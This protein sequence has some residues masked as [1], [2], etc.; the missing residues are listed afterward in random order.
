MRLQVLLLATGLLIL[1]DHFT[2][3]TAQAPSAPEN[4]QLFP[5]SSTS[6]MGNWTASPSATNYAVYCK[7]TS[8]STNN[9]TSVTNQTSVYITNLKPFTSY[10]CYVKA[11]SNNEEGDASNNS[12]STTNEAG[13]CKS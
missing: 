4:F 5:V 8:G 3:V 10:T 11:T 1:Y 13:T 2:Q 6:L 9:T 12:T 7:E